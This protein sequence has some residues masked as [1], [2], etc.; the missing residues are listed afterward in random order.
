MARTT[1]TLDPSEIPGA[2]SAPAA[3]WHALL[4]ALGTGEVLRRTV[5][6][7]A[8]AA[9][10]SPDLAA[11]LLAR[12]DAAGFVDVDDPGPGAD[13]PPTACLSAYGALRL[14][15]HAVESGDSYRWA[16]APRPGPRH[17]RQPLQVGFP[18]AVL[19]GE[20]LRGN[21]VNG[22]SPLIDPGAIDPADAAERAEAMPPRPGAG[23]DPYPR[24][25]PPGDPRRPTLLLGLRA[26]W[27]EPRRLDD[28]CP[29]CR[30]EPLPR[31][32]Y[33]LLCDR[34]GLDADNRPP[35]SH[36]HAPTEAA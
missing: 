17:R 23:R 6:A 28:P 11:D 7:I 4:D 10:L 22:W 35:R 31:H 25:A 24:L 32:A 8:S 18:E 36:H 14:G 16:D 2:E 3:V 13:G 33:C 30:G 27:C 26:D 20:D 15:R 21:R 5:E 12:L 29:G 9:G 1:P 19:D 34:W